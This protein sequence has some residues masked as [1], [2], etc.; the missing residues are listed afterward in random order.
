MPLLQMK[1]SAE[2]TSEKKNRL[3]TDLSSILSKVTGKPEA[4][5]MVTI[6]H[7][8]TCMAGEPCPA[9]FV[10][11][12]G[13]GGLDP[14]TNKKLS[15]EV[16]GCL[17]ASLGIEGDKIYLNFTDVKASNWGWNSGTF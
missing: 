10:D 12:R 5:V 3:L 14:K 11:I 2:I 7:A 17:S 4:Y 8:D 6:Q 15:E 16:C 9:A 13:I 1:T